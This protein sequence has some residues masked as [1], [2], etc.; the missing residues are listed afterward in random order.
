VRRG[1]EEIE[2]E[3]S[4]TIGKMDVLW[5][6]VGDAASPDSDRTY[7]ERNL[8]ALLAG[9]DGP[10]DL[11]SDTWLGCWSGRDAI[12]SSGLWN[13][14]HIYDEFD[15]RALDVLEAYVEMAEGKG[16]RTSSSIAPTGWRQAL[17]KRHNGPQIALL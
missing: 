10:L 4:E 8:I 3:V 1:E 11:P 17:P 12:R 9:R 7:L 15:P 13:I 2:L 14:N 16:L 5:L 6:E